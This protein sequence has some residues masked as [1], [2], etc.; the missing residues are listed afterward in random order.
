MHNLISYIPQEICIINIQI[1]RVRFPLG[2]AQD[3]R[4]LNQSAN[5][6]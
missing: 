2:V 1:S 3:P 4:Q 5:C 6:Q